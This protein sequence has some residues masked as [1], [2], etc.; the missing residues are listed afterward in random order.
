MKHMPNKGPALAGAVTAALL[1]T[2]LASPA[3][4]AAGAPGAAPTDRRAEARQH[5]SAALAAHADRF[6]AGSGDA[7]VARGNPVLDGDGGAHVRYDR[8]YRGLPV[9]GGD[10]VVH[11]D[12]A[13]GLEDQSVTLG[14]PVGVGTTERVTQAQAVATARARAEGRVDAVTAR[15]VVDA[16]GSSPALAWEVTVTGV[17][18]DQTPSE[19]HVVVDAATGAV[20]READEVKQGT[21]NSIYAGAVAIGTSGS[22]GAFSMSDP[23]RGNANTTDL[24]GATTGTGTVFTDADDVWGNGAQ[25]D[26]ASAGVDAHYGAQVT[27]DF[28]KNVLARNGIFGD[29]RGV[30]SRVHYGNA[31][32]NAFWD[33]AQ[34]TYGDGAGNAKPLV[35]IDIAGHE[36]THGVTENTANLTYSGE[37]GGLNE[38]TSDIFGT[39]VEFFAN[40][41]SDVGDYLIGEKVDIN[42]NGTPLRYMDKPS[43][44]GKSKDCWSSTLGGLDV[45]Y[46]SGPANHLFY[47]L[48]EGSG[49]KTI[50]GV[51]YN[52]P[53]C[54]GSTVAGIGRDAAARIWYRALSVYMT[55][56]TN[57]AGARQAAVNAAKDLYTAASTQCAAVEKAFTA[58]SVSGATC[59]TATPPP[60]GGNLVANPGFESGAASWTQTT[61]VIT[62]DATRA[63]SGT[64]LGWLNGYGT[65][66]TDS[67]SQAVVIPSAASASLSLWL[68]VVSS[69]T[70]TTTAFDTLKVQV[71]NGTTTTTL[72]TFSNLHKGAAYVQRTFNLT[73]YVGKTVTLKLVGAEDGALATSF[74]VDDVAVTTG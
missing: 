48:A 62:N 59:G 26:R 52:S 32:V 35:S 49:A 37:S 31:Y 34:M 13:G 66:H 8:T 30:R 36:M 19:L 9:L 23:T 17:R 51:A 68:R 33:G 12:R 40:S 6:R 63:R 28:Y 22:A 7:F 53:T 50:N 4:T 64:W 2:G 24:K 61:G 29:G 70:T 42:G 73:P 65:A 41:T 39:A 11:L 38:A 47:L 45:H 60:A 18:S 56:G 27:Y 16:V 3:A 15:K 57:Y 21:G 74:Y 5:A 46:S 54:D 67:L 43:R 58:I 44:D 69:E 72:G 14:R 10:V 25:S 55:S 1:A 71:V 20:R